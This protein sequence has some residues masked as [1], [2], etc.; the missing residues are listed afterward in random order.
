[1]TSA[2]GKQCKTSKPSATLMLIPTAPTLLDATLY[3]SAMRKVA[4]LVYPTIQVWMHSSLHSGSR[5]RRRKSWGA[6][7]SLLY[8]VLL[9]LRVTPRGITPSVARVNSSNPGALGSPKER[10]VVRGTAWA[11]P[12]AQSSGSA[13]ALP[14]PT[15]CNSTATPIVS[16]GGLAMAYS[17]VIP[18]TSTPSLMLQALSHTFPVL[19]STSQ[20]YKPVVGSVSS[21][22]RIAGWE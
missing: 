15:P 2:M 20:R 18:S 9:V 17:T 21:A 6:F 3:G 10:S 19:P 4:Y 8:K 14:A 16:T 11:P 7:E 5:A 22:R 12:P 13:I 1:M